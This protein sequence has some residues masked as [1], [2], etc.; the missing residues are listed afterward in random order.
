MI[1]ACPEKYAHG[2]DYTQKIFGESRFY[3]YTYGDTRDDLSHLKKEDR[4]CPLLKPQKPGPKS[5]TINN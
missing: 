5:R 4:K 1:C 3:E 2:W